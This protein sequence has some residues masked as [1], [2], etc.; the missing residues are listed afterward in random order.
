MWNL[1]YTIIPMTAA[2]LLALL[3]DWGG[4]PIWPLYTTPEQL[5]CAAAL[6]EFAA[7][8]PVS[9]VLTLGDNFYNLGICSNGTLAPY[10]NSCPNTTS[11]LTGTAQDPRFR[12]GF[13][14]VYGG[15][16][17]KNLLSSSSP[18]P[19]SSP[20]PFFI[21]AGN[22][23]ALGNVSASIAYTAL[24]PGGQWRHPDYYYR[25]EFS[26]GRN[27]TIEVFMIDTTIC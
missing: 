4:S 3:G 27:S 26:A 12:L 15:I 24:S 19:S 5:L 21:I 25:L 6:A 14:D 7:A 22:H 16:T 2:L 8:S 18:P 13:E 10:N 23:D 20:L 17:G 9:A 1:Y 11:P